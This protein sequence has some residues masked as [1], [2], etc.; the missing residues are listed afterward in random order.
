MSHPVVLL[1]IICFPNNI[2]QTPTHK[3][4]NSKVLGESHVERLAKKIENR[5]NGR[6]PVTFEIR[7]LFLETCQDVAT[8][9]DLMT[10]IP[11]SELIKLRDEYK[12]KVDKKNKVLAVQRRSV[13]KLLGFWDKDAVLLALFE[14]GVANVTKINGKWFFFRDFNFYHTVCKLLFFEL[15]CMST[16]FFFLP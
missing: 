2:E 10:K 14:R 16:T 11:V 1:L 5:R 13:G 3:K 12:E 9:H 7:K 4:N 15:I 6:I 8:E